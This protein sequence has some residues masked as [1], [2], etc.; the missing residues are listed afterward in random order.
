[1]FFPE[2]HLKNNEKPPKTH[3]S[4]FLTFVDYIYANLSIRKLEKKLKFYCNF[5][6][7]SLFSPKLETFLKLKDYLGI[8]FRNLSPES[9]TLL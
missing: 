4:T 1:M 8:F 9:F 3:F 5:L 2:T 6:E 7:L